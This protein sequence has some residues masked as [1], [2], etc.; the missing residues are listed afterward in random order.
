[1]SF[2]HQ[3]ASC[4]PARN[5]LP[6]RWGIERWLRGVLIR[7]QSFPDQQ[8]L[9]WPVFFVNP[10]GFTAVRKIKLKP[11]WSRACSPE[12]KKFTTVDTETTEEER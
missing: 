10:D 11:K 12:Q 7:E 8:S 6:A 9:I 4:E 5:Q 1:M 3:S 2:L